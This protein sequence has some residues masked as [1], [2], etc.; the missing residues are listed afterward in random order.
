MIQL[1]SDEETSSGEHSLW[2]Q[3]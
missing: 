3:R 2:L 1:T